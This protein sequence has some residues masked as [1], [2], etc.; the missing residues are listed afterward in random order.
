MDEK[1]SRRLKILSLSEIDQFK[2]R[3]PSGTLGGIEVNHKSLMK[4]LK[5]RGHFIVENRPF[6]G[7][8]RPDIIICPT[9]GPNALLNIWLQK[10]K[11]NCAC[12]Q[13]AHTTPDDMKG[14]FLPDPLVPYINIY[15]RNLYKFSE[16]LITPSNFSKAALVKLKIP[17][18]PPIVPVS[19]GV[20]LTKFQFS[21]DKR[22]AFRAY[23]HDKHGIDPA[24]PIIL[25]VGV[26]WARKGLDV[27]HE[28][29]RSFPQYHFIWVGNYITAKKLVD[30][31]ND[32]PN[33]TFTGYVDDI[34]GAYCG[35]DVFFFPSRAENQGIPLLEAAACK[36]PI[37]CR[38]LP[39]YDWIENGV[40]CI[41]EKTTAGFKMSLNRLVDDKALREKLTN[42]ALDNVQE[43]DI[44]KVLD[45][46][47]RIYRRAILLRKKLVAMG[48]K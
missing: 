9:Y 38:D 33:L 10:K 34:V 20:N 42:N 26:I 3:V 16:V 30:Q 37:L 44:E 18:K 48:R 27:Y 15:L 19:N 4:G 23:L 40:H 31:Y 25:C 14:G 32:L 21:M 5:A 35:S 1:L 7:N 46:V 11:Y 12:V 28:V 29:A 24:K 45:Q 13:H 39:T 41:K 17:T 36:L 47:E 6:P 43:H 2:K 22:T 8:R